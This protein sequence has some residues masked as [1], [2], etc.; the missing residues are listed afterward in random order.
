[1]NVLKQLM[2]DMQHAQNK[3]I[4][5]MATATPTTSTTVTLSHIFS[6]ILLN[7]A[8]LFTKTKPKYKV[9]YNLCSLYTLF[10][11]LGETFLTEDVNDSEIQ[12][13]DI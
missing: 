4:M 13:P 9:L 12:I 11:C 6:F 5:T 2:S 10:M 7:I 3:L 8:R 1:M